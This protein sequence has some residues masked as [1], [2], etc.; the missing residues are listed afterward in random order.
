MFFQGIFDPQA[1]P[2]ITEDSMKKTASFLQPN[3]TA[4]Q[5]ELLRALRY[6]RPLSLLSVSADFSGTTAISGTSKMETLLRKHLRST[7]TVEE[8]TESHSF[9]LLPETMPDG[10]LVMARRIVKD[11]VRPSGPIKNLYIG[12]SGIDDGIYRA[13]DLMSTA[14]LSGEAARICG[15]PIFSIRNFLD[16]SLS[17]PTMVAIVQNLPGDAIDHI[18]SFLERTRHEPEGIRK[19]AAETARKMGKKLRID[20]DEQELVT[21]WI[22]LHDLPRNTV[23]GGSDE[24]L[25]HLSRRKK[26]THT[27][28]L[29]MISPPDFPLGTREN[30]LLTAVRMLLEEV[31]IYSNPTQELFGDLLRKVATECDR[32]GLNRQVLALFKKTTPS[33]WL[34]FSS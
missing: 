33:E 19:A 28:L 34:P 29:G 3:G 32:Q 17:L 18:S 21:F 9:I 14:I 6:R 11:I 5:Q 23:P 26:V 20:D 8:D 7:D 25:P 12:I 16:K 15:G 2:P 22:L 27:K 1:L 24:V 30:A 10:A 4:I 31:V 13:D